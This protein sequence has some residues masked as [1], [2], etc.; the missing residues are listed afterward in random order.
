MPLIALPEFIEKDI[1]FV[2]CSSYWIFNFNPNFIVSDKNNVILLNCINWY[3]CK[4]ISNEFYS[5]WDWSI[6]NA[7]TQ[8]LH[9]E[10]YKR[11]DGIHN[12]N[13]MK[14]QIIKECAGTTHYD[15]HNIYN[16]KRVFNNRLPDWDHISHSFKN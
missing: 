1:D 11:E 5:Y 7:F 3:I 13:G 14:I 6:M 10:N 9:L 16:N 2:T 8:I 4:Y 12:L 15:A